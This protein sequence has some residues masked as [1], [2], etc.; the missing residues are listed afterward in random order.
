MYYIIWQGNW[1]E[2]RYDPL[3]SDPVVFPND[4]YLT[5][6]ARMGFDYTHTPKSPSVIGASLDPSGTANKDKYRN[7]INYDPKANDSTWRS[8]TQSAYTDPKVCAF[9]LSFFFSHTN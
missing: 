5:T 8:V 2:Q 6:S 9:L 7:V 1:V 3:V 4:R